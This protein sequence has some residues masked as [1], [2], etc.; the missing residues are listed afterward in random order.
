[1]E[2]V[3]KRLT[4]VQFGVNNRCAIMEQQK[5]CSVRPFSGVDLSTA[6]NNN[7]NNNNNNNSD[8]IWCVFVKLLKLIEREK[9]LKIVFEVFVNVL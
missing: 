5:R 4:V 7:N 9:G 6:C 2:V 1:M 3:V 8:L